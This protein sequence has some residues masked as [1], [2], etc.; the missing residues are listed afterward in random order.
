[1]NLRV[2][3]V[4]NEYPSEKTPDRGIFIKDL[5]DHLCGVGVDVTVIDYRRNFVAMSIESLIR[6]A[7]L[8]L[9]D[10]QF[11]APAGVIT[12]LT[13]RLVPFVV[14]VHRWDI[15]Q[16][17]YQSPLARIAS[18]AALDLAAGIVVVGRT[19]LN[20]V[21]KFVSSDANIAL[22]PKCGGN[23]QIQAGFGGRSS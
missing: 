1:M 6:S 2:G 15:L 16:F 13:P 9:L 8:D 10:A 3:I 4:T 5:V 17:P 21:R 23:E 19:I 18:V 7:Q 14:T 22:L 20:E 11:L 12:A